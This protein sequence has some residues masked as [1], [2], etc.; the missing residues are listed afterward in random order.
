MYSQDLLKWSIIKWGI[1]NNMKYYNLSGINPNP[2]SK[3]EEGIF[4][5]KKKWGGKQYTLWRLFFK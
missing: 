1:N 2:E 5:Y 4:R 3:K